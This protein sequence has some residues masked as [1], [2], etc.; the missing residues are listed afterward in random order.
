[1]CL[2]EECAS[3]VGQTLQEALQMWP[4]QMW[5]EQDIGK[6]EPPKGKSGA[7]KNNHRAQGLNGKARLVS[8]V[9]S[10]VTT[11]AEPTIAWT[12]NEWCSHW[13]PFLNGQLH[14]RVLVIHHHAF[15]PLLDTCL[16]SEVPLPSSPG[17]R[18]THMPEFP[19][20]KQER[21]GVWS[22]CLAGVSWV[23]PP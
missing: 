15:R 18:D 1:M 21:K 8:G 16:H 9:G 5:P 6:R 7:R 4:G 12:V 14:C 19:Q 23:P 13:G 10:P 20:R 2:K 17:A 11:Q 22:V 3:L